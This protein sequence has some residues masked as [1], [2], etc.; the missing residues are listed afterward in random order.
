MGF[1]GHT[2]IK[3]VMPT[4]L[5]YSFLFTCLEMYIIYEAFCALSFKIDKLLFISKALIISKA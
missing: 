5:S 2:E 1:D 3:L 4:I